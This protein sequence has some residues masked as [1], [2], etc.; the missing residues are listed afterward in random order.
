MVLLGIFLLEQVG[1]TRCGGI[2]ERV[3]KR[4]AI[5]HR[6]TSALGSLPA[7][8]LMPAALGAR[9]GCFN[10]L[11]AL[12]CAS[13]RALAG[14][15]TRRG[16]SSPFLRDEQNVSWRALLSPT[17]SSVLGTAMVFAI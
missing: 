4:Q 2:T 15:A 6:A 1:T 10:N 13:L 7:F 3:R 8:V 17:L 9:A 11:H 5:Y 14:T 12:G 16:L